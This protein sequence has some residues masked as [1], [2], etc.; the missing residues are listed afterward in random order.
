MQTAFATGA[1]RGLGFALTAGLVAGG[2]RIVAGQ[3]LP[4]WHELG[5]LRERYPEQVQIVPLDVGS[6]ASVVV[7]A[8]LAA[9]F[10]DR[11]D[12][13]IGNAGVGS[14]A[15]NQAIREP[16]D[17]AEMHRLY[18]VNALGGLRIVGALL[19]LLDTGTMK[20]LCFVSSEAGS[21]ARATRTAMYGYCLSGAALNMATR[22]LFND[23]QPQGYTFR[24]YHTGWLRTYM[25][26]E[27]STRSQLEPEEAAVPARA[28]FLP[29]RDDEDRL[30]LR[31]WQGEEWP[32]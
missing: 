26:G 11:I 2:W 8:V 16:Q 32:W 30:A 21:V 25:R 10:T 14:P 29:D 9:T 23:L 20:R 15:S 27:K 18:D 13:P 24:V 5:A 4:E 17:Y 28:Y 12:L 19:P 22:I 7:A 6:D 31:D 1:D 3:F